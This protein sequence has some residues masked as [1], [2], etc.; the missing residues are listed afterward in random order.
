VLVELGYGRRSVELEE[1]NVVRLHACK[2]LFQ[3]THDVLRR[4]DVGE[5]HVRAGRRRVVQ[6]RTGEATALGRQE[7]LVAPVRYVL[8]NALL[9]DPIVDGG[10][11]K[12]DAGIERGVKDAVGLLVADVAAARRASQLHRAVTEDGDIEAGAAEGALREVWHGVKSF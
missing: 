1:V 9:G 5:A 7:V 3:A 11:D 6:Q 2:A 4:K 10:V 12:V 8:A